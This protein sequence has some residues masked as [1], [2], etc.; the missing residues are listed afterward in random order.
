[1]EQSIPGYKLDE[2]K[3]QWHLLPWDAMEEVARIFTTGAFKYSPRNWEN[4]MAWSR[5][6]DALLRH[7][8]AMWRG[9]DIDPDSG[10]PHAAHVAANALFLT[11]YTLRSEH[12]KYD[13]RPPGGR[14]SRER[15]VSGTSA[16]ES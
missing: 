6:W 2:G 8:T 13:D 15:P 16:G 14:I 12:G 10:Q 11:A 9:E 3:T 4:G 5:P 7:S 1:M